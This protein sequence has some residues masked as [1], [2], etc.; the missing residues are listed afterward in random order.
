MDQN[1]MQYAAPYP[2]AQPAAPVP[3]TQAKSGMILGIIAMVLCEFPIGSIVAIFLGILAIRKSN[4]GRAVAN[5]GGGRKA[6]AIIGKI[7]GIVSLVVGCIM[8][9]VWPIY[10]VV[11][12]VICRVF[13]EA[14]ATYTPQFFAAGF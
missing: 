7:F 9:V 13:A 3:N 5:A 6:M 14:I 4:A 8:T 2:P 10:F 1:Q 12:V 11:F